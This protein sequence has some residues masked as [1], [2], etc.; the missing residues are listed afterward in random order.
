MLKQAKNN[1]PPAAA[2]SPVRPV[3]LLF[4]ISAFL[5]CLRLLFAYAFSPSPAPFPLCL[6]LLLAAAVLF[7]F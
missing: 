3:L 5:L 6:R 4:R 7:F 1:L 2:F